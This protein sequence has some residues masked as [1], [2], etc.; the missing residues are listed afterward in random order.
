MFL[1]VC[2]QVYLYQR[3]ERFSTSYSAKRQ[4]ILE[5]TLSGEQFGSYFGGSL[6]TADLNGDG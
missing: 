2:F 3:E 4:L 6:A 5:Q 1:R